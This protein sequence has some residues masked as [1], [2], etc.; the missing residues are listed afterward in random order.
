MGPLHIVQDAAGV[1]G[2]DS[3]PDCHVGQ[4][5]NRGVAVL[6]HHRVADKGQD[7]LF[8]SHQGGCLLQIALSCYVLKL[9]GE[10]IRLRSRGQQLSA[11]AYAGKCP[12]QFLIDPHLG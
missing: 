1:L 5:E 7:L 6:A 12:H 3:A 2:A 8:S 9:L 10:D 11:D 4:P